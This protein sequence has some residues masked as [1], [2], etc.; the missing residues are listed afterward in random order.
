M[1]IM[2]PSLLVLK[3]QFCERPIRIP[4]RGIGPAE[5][6]TQPPAGLEHFNRRD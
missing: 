3:L 2:H 4:Y 1:T 5:Y 6:Y